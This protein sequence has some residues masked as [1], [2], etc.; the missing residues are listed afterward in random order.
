M[1][2]LLSIFS[3]FWLGILTSVS[4]CPLASNVAAI[5]YLSR[6]TEHPARM[7]LAGFLYSLGRVITYVALGVLITGSLLNIPEVAFFLQNRMNQFLG[8]V[9]ILAGAILL[10]WVRPG[11]LGVVL[12]EKGVAR[13]RSLGSLGALLLGLL[14]ALSFCPV[15]AGLFFGTLIPLAL[16]QNTPVLLPLVYGLGTSLPVLAVA[17]AIAFGIK[18]LSRL[19]QQ[20][21]QLGVGLRNVTGWIFLLVGFYYMFSYVFI[22]LFSQRFP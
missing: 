9:L 6:E 7:L 17:L 12:S 5:S 21:S 14:F 1:A 18:G 16:Q 8:P 19:L 13:I 11:S 15:S 3:A 2:L 4:P 20:A 10:E 22:P